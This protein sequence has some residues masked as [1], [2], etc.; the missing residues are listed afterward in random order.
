[1]SKEDRDALILWA[2]ALVVWLAVMPSDGCYV[3]LRELVC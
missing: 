2:L 3:I 1:M